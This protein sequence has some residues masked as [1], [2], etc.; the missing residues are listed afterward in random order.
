MIRS[1]C[2]LLI[3]VYL[4][5]QKPLPRWLERRTQRDPQLSAFRVSME[6]LDEQLRA[7]AA[8]GGQDLSETVGHPM[9]VHLAAR[10]VEE[11]PAARGRGARWAVAATLLVVAGSWWTGS[12]WRTS[13][14]ALPA[15][16]PQ[17]LAEQLTTVPRY[18][19]LAVHE[20]A[21]ESQHYL[22]ARSPLVQLDPGLTTGLWEW[23]Q[24]TRELHEPLQ[25]EL[26]RLFTEAHSLAEKWEELRTRTRQQWQELGGMRG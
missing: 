9:A 19:R 3:S 13:P 10:S 2:E 17:L 14:P 5:N 12:W 15:V 1:T 4:D 22:A 8:P 26:G 11:R 7:T 23:E 21:Q 16:T 6:R 18:L 20:A 24:V 25:A